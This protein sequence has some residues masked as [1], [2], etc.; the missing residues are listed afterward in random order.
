MAGLVAARQRGKVGERPRS[1]S[2]TD[3]EV[4]RSLLSSNQFTV[5]EIA[6][7]LGTSPATL[8]RYLP[9]ARSAHS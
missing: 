8:Y 5:A 3:L 1:L 9:S 4:A 7:R 2:E 6:K